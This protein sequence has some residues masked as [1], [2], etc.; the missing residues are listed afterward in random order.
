MKIA[1]I[2]F[3]EIMQV[4]LNAEMIIIST[5]GAKITEHLFQKLYLTLSIKTN[6]KWI[7]KHKMWNLKFSRKKNHRNKSDSSDSWQDNKS[8]ILTEN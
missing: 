1:L 2:C 4:L 8:M 3:S 7:T 6:T 5:Y